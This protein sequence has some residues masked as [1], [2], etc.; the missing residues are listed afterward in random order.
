MQNHRRQLGGVP[1][2]ARLASKLVVGYVRHSPIERGKWR[3]IRMT[4]RFLVVQLAPGIFMR[5][6]GTSNVEMAITRDGVFEAETVELFLKMLAPGMT[7]FDVGANV[8][9]YTL[10]AADLVGPCGQVHAFEPTP[11]VAAKLRSNLDM[12][13]FG[14]VTVSE[15]AVSES[16]GDVILYFVEDD[17]ENNILAPEPGYTAS[18]TVPTVTLDEY[19]GSNGIGKVD[20]VKM[21]IEGAELKALR[22]ATRLLA[23]EQ[24]PVLF[25]EVNPRTLAFGNTRAAEVVDFL[26]QH[27]YRVG[28]VATYGVHTRFP[29]ANVIAFKPA[30]LERWPFLQESGVELVEVN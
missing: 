10:L 18:V 22:G 29:W 5:V 26:R 19:V 21:D 1:L 3:L 13:G 17:G 14:H 28:T 4:N 27:G 25:L 8:G 7:V 12:N 20:V 23:G 30:H 11:H 16:T 24:C 15:M 9:L 2:A 6:S